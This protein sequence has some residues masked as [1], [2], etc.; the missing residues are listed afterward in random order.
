VIAA[1]SS[2]V[3]RKT[4]VFTPPRWLALRVLMDRLGIET[5]SLAIA[6]LISRALEDA[7]LKP[8]GHRRESVI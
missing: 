7:D 8:F 1:V 4:L 6:V 5:P 2:D 3:L